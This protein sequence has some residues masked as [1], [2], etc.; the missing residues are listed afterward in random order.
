MEGWE[1]QTGRELC[2][3]P[4]SKCHQDPWVRTGLGVRLHALNARPRTV[5]PEVARLTWCL[6]PVGHSTDHCPQL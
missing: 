1:S 4:E 6:S 2:V 5:D 3:E